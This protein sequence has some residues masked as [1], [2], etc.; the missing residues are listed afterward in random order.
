MLSRRVCVWFR[1]LHVLLIVLG[2]MLAQR[3]VRQTRYEH[4]GV[5]AGRIIVFDH[6]YGTAFSVPFPQPPD[7]A[8]IIIP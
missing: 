8:M 1:L 5:N 2:L 6:Y 4:L 7:D 3:Y